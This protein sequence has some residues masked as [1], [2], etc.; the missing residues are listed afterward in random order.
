MKALR[1]ASLLLFAAA[2][3]AVAQSSARKPITQD[4]YD[5]WKSIQGAT[6]SHDGRWVVY[7]LVP[8]VGDGEL[9]VR[10]TQGSTEYRA[11][12]GYIARPRGLSRGGSEEEPQQGSSQPAQVTADSRF[13]VYSALPPREEVERA[14]RERRRGNNQPRG[15]M[16]IMSLADGQITRIDGV[17]S[18]RLP[19]ESG[20]F[21]FYQPQRPDSAGRDST[22][23]GRT[24]GAASTPGGQ[25]RP[26]AD[27]TSRDRP[28][29]QYGTV[30]VIRDLRTGTET[31][32][33]NVL[34]YTV[35][36]SA[37]WL[38]YTVSSRNGAEDGVY[39]HTLATGAVQPVMTGEG[40]YR[41]LT[42]DEK[43]S[44]LAFVSDR[45][46][47]G[48]DEARY[49]VYHASLRSPRAQAVVTS[50]MPGDGLIV[51]DRGRLD[52][53]REG[54]VLFVPLAPPAMDSIP[55]DSLADK[56]VFDLWHYQDPKLQPQQRLEANRERNR[57]YS[58]VYH[59]GSKRLVRLTNDSIT[60]ASLS[61]NG[62]A[63]VATSNVAYQIEQ[64]WGEGG[65]DLYA[66][67]PMTG[68]RTI[69][70]TRLRSGGQ[71]SPGGKYI[72]YFNDGAWHAWSFASKRSVNL[73]G[74][75]EGISFVQE[76]WDTPSD[77][78]P[79]G[80][81]GWTKNDASL[82]IYDRYDVWEVDPTGARAPRVVTDSVGRRNSLIFRLVNLDRDE[83][84]IDPAK[85]L[86][87]RVVNDDTR[88]S[89]FWRDQ[90]GVAKQ[91]E[92]VVMADRNFGNPQKAEDAEMYMV[93]Q[94]TFQE[95]PN[96]WVGPSLT[97][98]T[99]ITDA[100]PQ[101]REYRWGTAEHVRWISADGVPLKGILFKPEDFD[102]SKQYPMVVYFYEQLSQ[103][104]HNY[105][106]PAGRNTV[107]PT[108]YASNGYLVF[109]PDIHYEEGY[110]GPS[111]IKSI[112]PGVQMLITQGFVKPDGVGIAGQSWGGYQVAYMITQS[113]MF[114]AGFA[115]APVANM[116]SAYGGI[117]WS[118]GLARAFQYEKT[119]SRIGGSLWEYP[120]R[121]IENSPLFQVDRIETPLLIMHNDEDGAV[122]WY[123]GIEMFVA[124]RR[125]GKEA[126]LINYNG[127]GHN[128][129]KRAN[130]LDIDM[131]MQQFF[132][133]HL[134]GDPA[135]EWMTK[136]IPFIQ[137]GRDQIATRPTEQQTIT[138]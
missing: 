55:A 70:G 137:K 1:L 47:Y 85:P 124:M 119:Q 114:G 88:A 33:E 96:L 2:S 120:M 83:R 77:P 97:Q 109:F 72:T 121:Y 29:K 108:V 78:A 4:V 111:A 62:R 73:T 113:K 87:F 13:V 123:Q 54:N 71:L 126:Y 65:T 8:A 59:L 107:N 98:L 60:S 35:D 117:R 9:V 11:P 43:A 74:G 79:W 51:A 68:A 89:G 91:P 134:R 57:T 103:G 31:R 53:N 19:S 110:P 12:R 45:D 131:R 100:N 130:Q 122:P 90:L 3:P 6:L 7:S 94:S 50:A 67:D 115:G 104:L 18:F 112:V 44:Q 56:A 99:K 95:F 136:G 81:A 22:A 129:T 17:R 14:Q 21:L 86:L 127:D 84:A 15:H 135:P 46:E 80:I 105:S 34:A 38:A 61:E 138:P 20:A 10:A 23:G 64:M 58:A 41:L 36:D 63:G 125:H 69:I 66:I 40:N 28:R 132:G 106:A 128:P 32:V 52:F 25:A 24:P 75:V 42:L 76:T 37:K 48:K 5:I 26:I 93:T 30:L 39:L 118:S 102:P 133:H 16:G 82:L 92:Q 27:S 101:Q 49:T 116:T